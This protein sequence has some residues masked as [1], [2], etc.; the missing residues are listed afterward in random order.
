M[1]NVYCTNRKLK[2]E[3]TKSA[4]YRVWNLQKYI[5]NKALFLYNWFFVRLIKAAHKKQQSYL[6]FWQ[7]R[8][9]YFVHILD[10]F[11]F[12]SEYYS[13]FIMIGV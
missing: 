9:R 4:N 3:C 2:D 8:S 5:K 1:G 6:V 10:I 11:T 12:F 7:C 13:Y